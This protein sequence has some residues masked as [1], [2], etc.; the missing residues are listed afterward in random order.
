[1]MHLISKISILFKITIMATKMYN[2]KLKYKMNI[3]LSREVKIN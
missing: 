3:N 1:M 2:G